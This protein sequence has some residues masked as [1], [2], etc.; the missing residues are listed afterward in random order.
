MGT[1]AVTGSASGMGFE[2]AQRLRA[3]GHTVIGVD[4]KDSDVVADLSTEDG[5]RVAADAVLARCAGTLDGAI[6]AAGLGPA[7]GRE[8]QIAQVNF[9]GVVALLT[10]WRPALAR[11]GRAKVVVVSSNSTTTTPAVPKRAVRSLLAGD[12]DRAVRAVRFYGRASAVMIYAASKTAVS[13]WVRR[14]ATRAEWAGAGIRLNALAPGA[15]MTPLLE[16]QLADPAGAKAVKAFPVP[17]G[18]YGDA[19]QL[20]DWMMFMLSDAADFLCGSVVFV[21]G[22]SD[23]YF[24]PDAWPTR[25]PAKSVPRYLLRFLGYSRSRR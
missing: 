11:A 1:Y 6:L 18:G 15:I 19:G 2:A 16:E 25:V 20:A 13:H 8:R 4:I 5:R 9:F 23:A 21:D 24:R 17:V 7:S 14:Q 3:A 10:A 22:G 12:A